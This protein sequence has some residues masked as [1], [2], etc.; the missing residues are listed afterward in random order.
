M[1]DID[2][3]QVLMWAHRLE[4]QKK[5]LDEMKNVR[6]FDHIHSGKK[7]KINNEQ[8]PRKQNKKLK[9]NNCMYC[10][11][12]HREAVPSIWEN[13]QCVQKAEPFQCSML[14]LQGTSR[15]MINIP[16]AKTCAW[17][18]QRRG[19]PCTKLRRTTRALTQCVWSP[20]YSIA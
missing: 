12:A 4:V 2:S 6:D 16:I 15:C 3:Q 18:A 5:A 17:D 7:T 9:I 14:E 20:W 8:Q 11:A 13:V 1:S 10:G 19:S